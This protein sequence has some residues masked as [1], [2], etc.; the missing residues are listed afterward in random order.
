ME[1]AL[2]L[3][4]LVVGV[5]TAVVGVVYAKAVGLDDSYMVALGF[6]GE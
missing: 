5:V 2:S 4:S 6:I 3:V 1:S